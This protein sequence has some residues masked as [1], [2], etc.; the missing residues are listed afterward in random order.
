MTNEV[1]S[2]VTM[3]FE[4]TMKS[5]VGIIFSSR[6]LATSSIY[7]EKLDSSE[8]TYKPLPRYIYIHEMGEVE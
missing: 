2:L 6:I 5:Q 1:G 4:I 8:E 3:K 7:K